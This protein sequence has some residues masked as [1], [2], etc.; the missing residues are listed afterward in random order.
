MPRIQNPA[1][2]QVVSQ[3]ARGSKQPVHDGTIRPA[4]SP[5]TYD[6]H[7]GNF[8]AVQGPS[9]MDQVHP[10][11]GVGPDLS[12]GQTPLMAVTAGGPPRTSPDDFEGQDFGRTR[13]S[14]TRGEKGMGVLTVPPEDMIEMLRAMGLPDQVVRV[15]MMQMGY[16]L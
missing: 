12:L 13:L 8:E 2:A 4:I 9:T 1:V 16:Q 10:A 6:R 3:L 7:G 15:T 11:V 14:H 5:Y